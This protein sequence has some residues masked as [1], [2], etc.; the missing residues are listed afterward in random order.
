MRNSQQA[1]MGCG[2]MSL[3]FSCSLLTYP[4]HSNKI[5][6]SGIARRDFLLFIPLRREELASCGMT[7]KGNGCAV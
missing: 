4:L 6:S 2:G 7:T 1:E 3:R 5:G